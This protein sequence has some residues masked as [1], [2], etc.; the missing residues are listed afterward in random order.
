MAENR[1][2]Y[3]VQM[4]LGE[5]IVPI[6]ALH[7]CYHQGQCD[8]DVNYWVAQCDFCGISEDDIRKEL[9]QQGCWTTEEL[10]DNKENEKR[11]LWI[12]AGNFH[13]NGF[14]DLTPEE[15]D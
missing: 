15:Q 4:N 7:D 10:Q 2:R 3:I 14:E 8:E 13:D 1:R 12:A 5:F 6:Q 9:E 11:I